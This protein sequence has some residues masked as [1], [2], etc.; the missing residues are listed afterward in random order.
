MTPAFLKGQPL[1]KI[2]LWIGALFF[3]AEF[4]LHFFGMAPLEHDKIFMPT[5]DRYIAAYA[6]TLSCMSIL[7]SLNLKKYRSFFVLTMM[8][9]FLG[10]IIGTMIAAEGGY[11]GLFPV[12]DL[13][14]KLGGLGS[15]FILWYLFT[16]FS[17]FKNL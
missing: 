3:L 11:S 13:D 6:L 16:C 8:M 2:L 1:T 14:E 4:F 5:H 15:L 9:M 17:Y 7:V 10:L 12:V